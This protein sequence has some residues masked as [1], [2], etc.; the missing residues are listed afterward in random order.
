[1]AFT[2][3]DIRTGMDVYTMAGRRLGTVAR[4]TM[5]PG[6]ILPASAADQE[7]SA[8]NGEMFGP[9]PT[10]TI[11]NTGP[12]R[13]S[14]AEGFAA[15]ADADTASVDSFTVARWWPFPGSRT[16]ECSQVL[17]VSMEKVII[18]ASS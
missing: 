18:T 12:L 10:Q 11:G 5:L 16:V 1:M 3:R 15:P 13:Q 8:V 2:N 17:N 6:S 9:A 7:S 4:V 14:A